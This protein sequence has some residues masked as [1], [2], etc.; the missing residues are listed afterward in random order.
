MSLGQLK[1]KMLEGKVPVNETE[2]ERA[3]KKIKSGTY[4][5]P[6]I[7]THNKARL[8]RSQAHSSDLPTDEASRQSVEY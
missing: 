5:Q 8:S 3:L 6:T 2:S 7:S 1:T 4:H